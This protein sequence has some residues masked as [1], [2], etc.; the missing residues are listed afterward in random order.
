MIEWTESDRIPLISLFDAHKIIRSMIIPWLTMGLGTVIVDS[1]SDPSVAVLS[2]S[3][4]NII[5]G[6]SKSH[7]SIRYVRSFPPNN[8]LFVPDEEWSD[9]VREEWGPK[10]RIQHRTR[11]D[12]SELDLTKILTLKRSIPPEYVIERIDLDALQAADQRFWVTLHLMFDSFAHFLSTSFGFCIR[13]NEKILSAAYA[14]FPFLED[15]EIQVNTLNSEEYRQKG[16][17]T[18]VCAALLEFGLYN[19]LTPH[20]DAA[21]PISVKLALKLGF[22][23]PVAYDV[24]YWL[25]KM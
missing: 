15:F 14:C 16:L 17:A 18:A 3:V 1:I 24:F 6:D 19:N 5:T 23:N 10:L 12:S 2:N 8:V 20:W 25:D 11:L 21:N 7:E 22:T 9:L 13:K 4:M